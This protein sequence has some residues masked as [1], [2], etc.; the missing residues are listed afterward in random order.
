[1]HWTRRAD[2]RSPQN[3]QV[4]ARCGALVAALGALVLALSCRSSAVYLGSDRAGNRDG[5]SG[6]SGSDAAGATGSAGS[7][8]SN[9]STGSGEPGAAGASNTP[10]GTGTPNGMNDAGM[11]PA[12]ASPCQPGFGDCDGN[13]GNGCETDILTTTAHCGGCNSPCPRLPETIGSTCVNGTCNPICE[14]LH[15]DCDGRRE[16]GCEAH[17]WLDSSNCGACGNVCACNGSGQCL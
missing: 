8:G 9:G 16:N 14:P 10:G 7:S 3:A 5:E 17:L 15:E 11:P 13:S 4:A 2:P 6:A 12:G 1:M